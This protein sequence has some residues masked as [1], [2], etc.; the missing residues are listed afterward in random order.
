MLYPV[1]SFH[2]DNPESYA[3]GVFGKKRQSSSSKGGL[4]AIIVVTV[5]MEIVDV[6][7]MRKAYIKIT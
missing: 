5:L 6:R 4:G 3:D 7:K 1:L 2:D